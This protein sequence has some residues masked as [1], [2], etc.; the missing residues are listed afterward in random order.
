MYKRK[1]VGLNLLKNNLD[2]HLTIFYLQFICAH[3]D[4][5][6]DGDGCVNECCVGAPFFNRDF[7]I[8]Y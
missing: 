8:L 2:A 7:T 4:G 3:D 1:F 6:V 5:D